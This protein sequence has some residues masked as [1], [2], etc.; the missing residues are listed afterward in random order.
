MNV[1]FNNK[2]ML[3]LTT[4]GL[5]GILCM[6][7]CYTDWVGASFLGVCVLAQC[8]CLYGIYN[9]DESLMG[10]THIMFGVT[11]FVGTFLGRKIINYIL[12]ILLLFVMWTRGARGSCMYDYYTTKYMDVIPLNG[13]NMDIYL[14]CLVLFNLF[15]IIYDK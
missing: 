2:N 8:A 6:C 11:I 10:W 5:I 1:Y 3:P 4:I 12:V 14:G 13:K 7:A 9:K 15:Y